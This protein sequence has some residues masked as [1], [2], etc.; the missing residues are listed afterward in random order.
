MGTSAT[1]GTVLQIFLFNPIC[2]NYNV[3]DTEIVYKF[4]RFIST[5]LHISTQV[6][7]GHGADRYCASLG[8]GIVSNNS[9]LCTEKTQNDFAKAKSLLGVDTKDTKM[10]T[11]GNNCYNIL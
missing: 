8:V 9:D 6:L 2:L 4:S 1:N 11:A 10:D 3:R 5:L 7:T